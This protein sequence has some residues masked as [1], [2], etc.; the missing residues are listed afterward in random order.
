[1]SQPKK[2]ILIIDDEPMWVR[3]I[4][5]FLHE[6]GYEVRSALNGT[7]A[8]DALRRFHPDLILSDVRMPDINGFDL[9]PLIKQIPS[10]AATPV[11]FFSAIDDFDARKT[12]LALG[13]QDYVVKPFDAQDLTSVLSKYFPK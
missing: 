11:V 10:A 1:M 8:L 5:Y 7:E 13:A 12:A 6:Q 4:E 3:I 9:L 2:Q